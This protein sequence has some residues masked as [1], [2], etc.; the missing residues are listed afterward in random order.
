MEANAAKC[1]RFPAREVNVRRGGSRA[2]LRHAAAIGKDLESLEGRAAFR[3]R[4]SR[5]SP[6]NVT[7][8]ISPRMKASRTLTTCTP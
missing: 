6:R 3:L 5:Y 2:S 1:A 4:A 7:L 8:E